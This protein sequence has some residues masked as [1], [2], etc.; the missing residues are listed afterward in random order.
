VIIDHGGQPMAM[1]KYACFK[2]GLD[3]SD[4]LPVDAGSTDKMI[5]AYRNGEADFVHLQGPAPQ[6]LVHDG[7]GHIL[8]A[9]GDAIGPCAFSSLAARR[10]W[11]ASDAAKAFMRAYRKARAWLIQTPAAEVAKAEASFFS[12]IDLPVLTATIATYQ[13]LGNWTPHVEITRPAFAATL[14]IFQ[15][16]GL[17]TKRHAYEDVVAAPPV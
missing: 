14:D 2:Q 4:V 10:E 7:K 3:F 13:K 12:D 17:I 9:L 16:A 8:A 15:H 6:Q 1:F 5:A 11:L